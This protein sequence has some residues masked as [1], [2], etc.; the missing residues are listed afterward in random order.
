MESSD[1][2]ASKLQAYMKVSNEDGE[3]ISDKLDRVPITR[4]SLN[5]QKNS[6]PSAAFALPVGINAHIPNEISNAHHLMRQYSDNLIVEV[7]VSGQGDL[8]ADSRFNNGTRSW[9]DGEHLIWKGFITG[10]GYQLSNNQYLFTINSSHW[11]AALDNASLAVATLLKSSQADLSQ[12]A[13]FSSNNLN[14]Q[15][16]PQ[17]LAGVANEAAAEHGNDKGMWKTYL[18]SMFNAMMKPSEGEGGAGDIQPTPV[19]AD[20]VESLGDYATTAASN[21][22]VSNFSEYP[23]NQ[24]ALDVFNNESDLGSFNSSDSFY[25]LNEDENLPLAHYDNV[26]VGDGIADQLA[27]L[28]AMNVGSSSVW[29]KLVTI[30][31][32]FL[33]NVIAN[34]DGLALVPNNSVFPSTK[35]WRVLKPGTYLQVAG[36]SAFP[37]ALAGIALLGARAGGNWAENRQQVVP[38]QIPSAAFI[39]L[40]KGYLKIGTAPSWLRLTGPDNLVNQLNVDEAAED[41]VDDGDVEAVANAGVDYAKAYWA[42]EHYKT[43]RLTIASPFRLDICPGSCLKLEGLNIGEI[44]TS[45]GLGDSG[46]SLFGTVNAVKVTLDSESATANTVFEI[47]HVRGLRDEDDDRG[48]IPEVHPVY[49]T[50][51]PGSPLVQLKDR[52]NQNYDLEPEIDE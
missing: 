30:G 7:F 52:R 18:R 20:L 25:M 39:G 32:A 6:V 34:V 9:P 51:W 24:A 16:V 40:P 21:E 41:V 46:D 44:F 12:Y 8:I 50:I 35:V 4:L 10:A 31:Q 48:L 13:Q 29:D 43:R 22:F 17:F 38:D 33:F 36:Q 3:S 14:G 26:F 45:S 42:D 49:R 23:G 28:F 47:S 37:R 5:F 15:L 11:V 19:Y 27:L 2:F 1:I